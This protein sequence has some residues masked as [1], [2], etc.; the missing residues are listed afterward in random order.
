MHPRSYVELSSPNIA[1]TE[2][3]NYKYKPVDEH[4][5]DICPRRLRSSRKTCKDPQQLQNPE[6]EERL[7]EI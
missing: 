5:V 6:P 3:K 1:C 4:R 7:L 2:K